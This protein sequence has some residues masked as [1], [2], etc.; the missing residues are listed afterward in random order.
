[1]TDTHDEV[2]Q[3]LNRRSMLSMLRL[4]IGYANDRKNLLALIVIDIDRFTQINGSSGYAYGD[5]VLRHLAQQIESVARERDYTARIGDNRFALLLPRILNHG[6][7]ELAVQK[8]FRLLEVPFESGDSRLTL[9]VTVG[10]ALCPSHA[11]HPEY[12]LRK[13]ELALST[14]R[15]EGRRYLFAIDNPEG[16]TLSDL[17]DLEFAL[18]G[19]IE[20]GEVSMH[21]QPLL[22]ASDLHVIG[23]EALMR[24]ESRPRGM[25]APDVFIPIAERTGQIKKLTMWSLN[26]ALRQAGEW[27]HAWGPLTVAVN[28]SS[29]LVSQRDLPEL[30]E[31][32][33]HL[34]GKDQVRLV[35]EITE[36]SLMNREHALQILTQLRNL[37]VKISID[38]FGTGY[39]CLAYFKNI[40]VDELKIDKSFVSE[41]LIDTA[42]AAITALIIGLA[43]RFGLAVVAEGVEDVATFEM[44]KAGGCDSA[45]GFLFARPMPSSEF[46]TWLQA[47]RP[48]EGNPNPRIS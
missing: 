3:L 19:V 26:T 43:H 41:I 42:S 2:T 9:A 8:L 5:Q 16:D 14:A 12:L 31:N 21:Y 11:T 38:D 15:L 25:I 20:R 39:S 48:G 44:L 33:L 37:G 36:R 23:A 6:H 28:L 10:V 24:W 18:A 32:A 7:A 35:L 13:A 45:Q 47:Y 17:W 1:M 30:V 22:R 46:Q 34:W 40:P 27:K 29:D 4:Q